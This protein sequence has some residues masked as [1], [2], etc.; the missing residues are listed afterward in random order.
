MGY[1][2]KTQLLQI[3]AFVA[4]LFEKYPGYEDR[5]FLFVRSGCVPGKL[6]IDKSRENIRR[7]NDNNIETLDGKKRL[8]LLQRARRDSNY[9][10]EHHAEVPIESHK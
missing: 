2:D 3:S 7:G 9:E 6:D 4:R 8:D 10:I 1:T 5:A